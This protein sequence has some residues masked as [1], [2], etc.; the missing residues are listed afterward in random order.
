M[1]C[2]DKIYIVIR[3]IMVYLRKPDSFIDIFKRWCREGYE[4]WL[5]NINKPSWK[6]KETIGKCSWAILKLLFNP[7]Q[8]AYMVY[9]FEEWVFDE[10]DGHPTIFSKDNPTLFK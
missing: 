8:R 2:L 7:T 10:E 5:K 1:K 3:E 4:E 9:C 6:I